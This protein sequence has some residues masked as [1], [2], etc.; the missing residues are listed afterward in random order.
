MGSD[1][2]LTLGWTKYS[3]KWV[4]I[5]FFTPRR[6]QQT[7][8]GHISTDKNYETFRPGGRDLYG[9]VLFIK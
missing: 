2:Y 1:A 6:Y 3:E 4:V 9:G 8:H 7:G 5:I